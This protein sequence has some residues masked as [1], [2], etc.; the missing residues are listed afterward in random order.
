MTDPVAGAQPAAADRPDY[1]WF[2]YLLALASYVALGVWL[3]S[4]VLNWIVGPLYLLVVFY[5]VPR[6]V[7]SL[8]AGRARR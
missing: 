4:A 6:A 1:A 2:W 5:L 3:R 7:R 8:T